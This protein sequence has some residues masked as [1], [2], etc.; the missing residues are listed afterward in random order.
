MKPV[1][2]RCFATAAFSAM[3]WFGMAVQHEPQARAAIV[4]CTV[5]A[6]LDAQEKAF[7]TLINDYRVQNGRM[8]LTPSFKLSRA[9]QWKSNDMGV[10]AYFAH[11]DPSRTW[12]QRIRDCGYGYNAWL[13][14]NIAA[15]YSTAQTVFEGWRN[16]PGHNA[17]ML[18]ENYTAIG[19][20]RAVVPGS[21]YGVYWTT[22]FGSVSDGWASATAPGEP[23]SPPL[24][25]LKVVTRG[26]GRLVFHIETRNQEAIRRVDFMRM[27][28][29]WPAIS[30]RRSP[31]SCGA[32]KPR[33]PRHGSQR[34]CGCAMGRCSGLPR[35]RKPDAESPRTPLGCY[36]SAMSWRA[37][38]QRGITRSPASPVV[39]ALTNRCDPLRR[40]DPANTHT[41]VPA[42]G[43]VA[44]PFSPPKPAS[45]PLS[46]Y[47]CWAPPA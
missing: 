33:R 30:A 45:S 42:D 3:L 35:R 5:D 24:A 20:G 9:A 29:W 28:Y 41:A 17:N 21:P 10:N 19:I 14:E 27:E 11:D 2:R 34:T 44:F 1:I 16:S 18:G 40:P 26:H 25:Q 39:R 47:A 37:Q 15:G 43:G 31:P 22:E 36:P 12:V 8:P 13:G 6:T 38:S 32:R 7:L 4:N 23:V 46:R